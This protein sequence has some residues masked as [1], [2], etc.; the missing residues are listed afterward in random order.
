MTLSQKIDLRINDILSLVTPML[1]EGH[2]TNVTES[3]TAYGYSAYITIKRWDA[4]LYCVNVA[5][6][7][8]SD[9]EATNPVRQATEIMT[10]LGDSIDKVMD[11]IDRALNPRNW[12]K[13]QVRTLNGHT[14]T[15]TFEVDK[16][17]YTT[18]SEPTFLGEVISK[19]GRTMHKYSWLQ[20]DVVYVWTRK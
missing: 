15:A 1:P 5:K 12:E 17:P 18:L 6:I 2:F 20:E 3:S 7:R 4:E 11:M 9:H 13:V 10:D 8:V 16:K 14:L 19:S